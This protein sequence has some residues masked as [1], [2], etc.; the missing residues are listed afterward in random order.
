MQNQGDWQDAAERAH[1]LYNDVVSAKI[2]I[3]EAE[4]RL[5]EAQQRYDT[6]V[7]QYE[8]AEATSHQKFWADW[9]EAWQR[10]NSPQT[11]SEGAGVA[12]P[13]LPV[14]LDVQTRKR[15][16]EQSGQGMIEYAL[17]LTLIALVVLVALLWFGP[18][19]SNIFSGITAGL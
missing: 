3:C 13:M 10:G 18:E 7:K 9:M 4:T 17:I 5:R 19:L 1:S 16:Q 2:E 6:A 8:Q 11:H 15:L 12:F 14:S